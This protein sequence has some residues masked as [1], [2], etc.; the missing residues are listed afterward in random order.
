MRFH[1][2]GEAAP[3]GAL[4]GLL[5]EAAG[6]RY[7]AIGIGPLEIL[8]I[9]ALLGAPPPQ[10]PTHDP[11]CSALAACGARVTRAA[12]HALVDGAFHARLTLDVRG[13]PAELD[14]R[15][16]DAIPVAV[17]AGIPVLVEEAVLEQAGVTPP[18]GSGAAG[19]PAGQAGWERIGEDQL[20]AFRDVSRGPDLDDLD[21]PGPSG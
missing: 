2:L 5:E 17:R 4:V 10:P 14:S 8:G 18:P 19:A 11:L 21:R 7:L 1:G 13:Q 20:G 15:S 16:S 6:G 3:S 12:I 9:A